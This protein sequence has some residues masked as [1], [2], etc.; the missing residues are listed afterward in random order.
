MWV[1]ISLWDNGFTSFGYISRCGI[2]GSYGSSI[3]IFLSSLHT[4][5][6]VPV[7]IPTNIVQGFPFL[8][9]LTTF[10]SLS[11]SFFFLIISLMISDAE[12]LCMYL[13]TICLSSLEKCLFMLFVHF[14]IGLHGL[15]LLSCTNFFCMFW[16]LT[17]FWILVSI[18]S[19][20][21]SGSFELF[22]PL[23][24]VPLWLSW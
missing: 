23:Y 6:T 4:T 24:G 1:Q 10:F 7:Y 13:L 3:F 14:K 2:A 17:P 16:I 19:G 8:H 18:I 9:I 20:E 11:L 21:K 12:H 15:F 22:F 5:V